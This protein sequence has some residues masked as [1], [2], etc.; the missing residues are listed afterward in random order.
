LAGY[1][2]SKGVGKETL[3]P[4]C[5]ERGIDMIIGILGILKAGG[6]YVPIDPEYPFDRISYML[7]DTAAKI[8]VSNNASRLKL[9]ETTG[10][11]TIAIDSDWPQIAKKSI[12]NLQVAIAPGQLAYIIYTSGSTGKPKGVMIEHTNVVRLF[13]NDA[14]LYDFNEQDTWSMFHSFVST[15]RYGKCTDALVLWRPFGNRIT[16]GDKGRYAV[17]KADR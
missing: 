7:E 5:I 10:L 17:L 12:K 15:F 3:V 4:I 9:P 8:V 14:S 11:E 13:K 1:L 6:A 2:T 16:G